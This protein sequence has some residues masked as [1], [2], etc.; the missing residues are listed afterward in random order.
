MA[1]LRIPQLVPR[2]S[3][4]TGGGA[5][6]A[7]PRVVPQQSDTAEQG[8]KLGQAVQA[9]GTGL[10]RVGEFFQDQ[11]DD[12]RSTTLKNQFREKV[13]EIETKAKLLQ[14]KDAVEQMPSFAKQLDDLRAEFDALPEN[15][16]QQQMFG[17]YA[18]E[19]QTNANIELTRH[20]AEQTVVFNVGAQ[21]AKSKGEAE[22]YKNTWQDPEK[23]AAHKAAALQALNKKGDMEGWSDE[24]RKNENLLATTDMHAGVLDSLVKKSPGTAQTYLDQHK[25]E[26]TQEAVTRTENQLQIASD[27][28]VAVDFQ[29]QAVAVAAKRGGTL[30]EQQKY[31]EATL[32]ASYAGKKLTAEQYLKTNSLIKNSYIEQ[33]QLEGIAVNDAMANAEKALSANLSKGVSVVDPRDAQVLQKAGKWGAIE[34]YADTGRFVTDPEGYNRILSWT[35]EKHR[36]TSDAEFQSEISAVASVSGQ[37]RL[38]AER[39]RVIGDADKKDAAH[40]FTKADD[41]LDVIGWKALKL[42]TDNKSLAAD[43]K[44]FQLDDWKIAA[45]K[46]YPKFLA[47][48]KLPDNEA[49]ANKWLDAEEAASHLNQAGKLVS[50][51]EI[52]VADWTDPF[53]RFQNQ[54]IRERDLPVSVT[55][56]TDGTAKTKTLDDLTREIAAQK[57]ALGL[58]GEPTKQ[59]IAAVMDELISVSKAVPTFRANPDAAAKRAAL[60]DRVLNYGAGGKR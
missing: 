19:R 55:Y 36:N 53:V 59:E 58:T 13:S 49:N 60:Y 29:L 9:A 14:G 56:T 52:P 1:S 24:R 20:K 12:A 28:K 27:N 2:V 40:R 44:K 8:Q 10:S 26:M 15:G 46:R 37:A 54:T 50:Q 6:F 57:K 43:Q 35:E 18:D 38:W 41:R 34:R 22:D 45:T 21:D 48:N 33:R 23:A 17:A 47:D 16:Q 11:Y 4:D 51:F 3:V 30:A 7:A 32:Q 25:G 31:A 5:Q 39:H 42:N